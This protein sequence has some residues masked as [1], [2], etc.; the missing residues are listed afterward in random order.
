MNMELSKWSNHE[1]PASSAS[2][3]IDTDSESDSE[4]IG[5]FVF[6][7]DRT[8][9]KHT[10]SSSRKFAVQRTAPIMIPQQSTP[11]RR[12]RSSLEFSDDMTS[13]PYDAASPVF[14]SFGDLNTDDIDEDDPAFYGNL[15]YLRSSHVSRLQEARHLGRGTSQRR[16]GSPVRASIADDEQIFAMEL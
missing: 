6:F 8:Q 5:Q 2:S 9:A 12:W 7:G 4:E 11:D 16:S 14:D 13:S 3:W 15:A 1:S 10:S